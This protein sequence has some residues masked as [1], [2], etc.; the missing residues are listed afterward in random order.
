MSDMFKTIYELGIIPVVAIDDAEK[1]VP[2]AKALREGGLPA[3]EITFRTAAAEESADT[4]TSDSGAAAGLPDG[5]FEYNGHHYQVVDVAMMWN[6]AQAECAAKGGYLACI[7]SN[8]EQR[9]I[10]KFIK[11]SGENKYHYWLG[12]TAERFQMPFWD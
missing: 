11:K 8:E 2:L 5:V 9:N 10:E 6:E 7:E 3:A 4:S 12:G 1:A